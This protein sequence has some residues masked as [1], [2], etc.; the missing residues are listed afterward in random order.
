MVL[1]NRKADLSPACV[2][3]ADVIVLKFGSSVLRTVQD[4][5]NAAPGSALRWF[6]TLSRCRSSFLLIGNNTDA[7]S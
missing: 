4:S 5:L 2:C 1:K 7:A 6:A 3:P